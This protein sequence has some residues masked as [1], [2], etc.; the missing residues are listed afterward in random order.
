MNPRENEPDQ[1][2]HVSR[3]GA[4]LQAALDQFSVAPAGWVCADFGCNTGGFTECLLRCGAQKVYAIDTGYGVLAWKLRKD[5]RVVVLE[6]TNALH[7]QLD[8][9]LDLVVIDVA[10]TRQRLILPAARRLLNP[11]GSIIS[12]IKPHYE[13]DQSLLRKGVLQPED[14]CQVLQDTLASLAQDG[15]R[16]SATIR[17]PIV[18]KKGNE[19]YL[20][21][22]RICEADHEMCD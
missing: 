22:F 16:P 15:F 4:K 18:G 2:P 5:E 7:V 11:N 21:I 10:W 14:A 19:E 12:L 9:P 13:A 17:S 20:A 3:A 6:R 1:A 8:E